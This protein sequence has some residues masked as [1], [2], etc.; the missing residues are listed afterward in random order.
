[1]MI[2]RRRCRFMIL[3]TLGIGICKHTFQ[4]GDGVKDRLRRPCQCGIIAIQRTLILKTVFI[5][6]R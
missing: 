5:G 4:A 1:M 2:L 3:T 6:E